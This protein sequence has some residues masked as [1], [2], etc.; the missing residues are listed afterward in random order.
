[1]RLLF[2]CLNKVALRTGKKKVPGLT[3]VAFLAVFQRCSNQELFKLANSSSVV[4]SREK[5]GSSG[6]FL[7][8]ITTRVQEYP[9]LSCA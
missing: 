9:L 3:P 7:A 5:A 2:V 6:I 1:M 8:H 4:Y